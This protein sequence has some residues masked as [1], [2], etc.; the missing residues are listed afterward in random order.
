M[1][2]ALVLVGVASLLGLSAHGSIFYHKKKIDPVVKEEQAKIGV[3]AHRLLAFIGNSTDTLEN[4]HYVALVGLRMAAADEALML[5]MEGAET[6]AYVDLRIQDL[7]DD[8]DSPPPPPA[9]LI[10]DNRDSN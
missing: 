3:A 4:A 1:K 5:Y 9:P 7:V 6:K 2:K 10:P 8:L